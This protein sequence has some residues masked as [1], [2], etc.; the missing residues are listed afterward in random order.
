MD[1]ILIEGAN[2]WV[3][4]DETNE[5][6]FSKGKSEEEILAKSMLKIIK[7]KGVDVKRVLDLMMDKYKFKM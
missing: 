5:G 4:E 1:K 6:M 3:N 7:G 2:K